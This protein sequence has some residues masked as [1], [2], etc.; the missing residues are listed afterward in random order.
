MEGIQV[1]LPLGG[2]L[3]KAE[4]DVNNKDI[5]MNPTDL[6]Q[7]FNSSRGGQAGNWHTSDTRTTALSKDH[8][9]SSKI[10]NSI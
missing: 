5:Q 6:T 4:D 10:N 7:C 9:E 1:E 2:L 8:V 3:S